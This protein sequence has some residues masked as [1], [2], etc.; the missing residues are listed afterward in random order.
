MPRGKA[1]PEFEGWKMEEMAHFQFS[2]KEAREIFKKK[3]MWFVFLQGFAGVFPW[4]VIT[5]FFFGYLMPKSAVTIR[6]A[7]CSR[8]HQSILILAA[9]Y[10]IGGSLGDAAFKRTNKGR[11]LVSS[12]GV[13]MGAYLPVP[14][15]D[16]AR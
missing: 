1:E 16:Y 13:L 2:W 8:W 11:I 3:T 14:R 9:G 10:F 4:N 6:T 5:Y 15:H 12:I 7:C